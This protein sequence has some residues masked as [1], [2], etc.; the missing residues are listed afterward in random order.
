MFHFFHSNDKRNF[1]SLFPLPEGRF[2]NI[3]LGTLPHEMIY[4]ENAGNI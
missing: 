2:E 4:N 3:D 1:G